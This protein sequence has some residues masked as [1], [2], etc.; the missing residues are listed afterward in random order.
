MKWYELAIDENIIMY[1]RHNELKMYSRFLI[2]YF[3]E[4]QKLHER[5]GEE[6]VRAGVLIPKST[7]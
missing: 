2:K 4:I 5:I 1:G 3:G 7:V 6:R